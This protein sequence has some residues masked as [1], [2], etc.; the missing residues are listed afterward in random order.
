MKTP[1][2][3]FLTDGVLHAFVCV[4][5]LLTSVLLW[6]SLLSLVSAEGELR[7]HGYFGMA[8]FKLTKEQSVRT[9]VPI[10]GGVFIRQILP[11]GAAEKAGIKAGD[12]V[13]QLGGRAVTGDVGFAGLLRGLYEGDRTELELVR[14]GRPMTVSLVTVAPPQE[15]GVGLEIQ[16]THF[17]SDSIRLRAVVASP[18]SSRGK[19]LPALLMVSSLIGRRLIDTPRYDSVREL[20]HAVARAGF[21][22]LRFEVRG[23]GDSEGGDYRDTGFYTEVKDNCAAFDALL[24]RADVDPARVFV[25]GHSTEAMEAAVLA[26]QRPIAGLISSG[27]IGRTFYER[28]VETLRLQSTLKGA[29]PSETDQSIIDYIGFTAAVA[30]GWSR[31]QIL[32]RNPAYEQYFNSSGRIMD[33]R[34]LEFWREQ[35]NLNLAGTYGKVKAPVLLIWGASD[36]L[37]QRACHEHIKDVLTSAGNQDVILEIIPGIDHAYAKAENYTESFKNYQTGAFE[38]NTAAREKVLAWLKEHTEKP[39]KNPA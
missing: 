10:E 19:R 26:T 37:T 22:V 6:S 30:N 15:K 25:Y 12:V 38:E 33:D 2:L 5:R 27:T 29:T 18:E 28:M 4:R 11:G 35:L 24:A 21:R 9:G 3:S 36:F 13:T 34:N 16:Y 1:S 23:F 31:E 7:R 39:A 32:A 8:F 20:A 17:K 14:E